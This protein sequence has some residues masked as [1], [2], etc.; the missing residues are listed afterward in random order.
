MIA[1][2]FEKRASGLGMASADRSSEAALRHNQIEKRRLTGT[3]LDPLAQHGFL[4][5]ER[6]GHRGVSPTLLIRIR[7]GPS[8]RSLPGLAR[9]ASR[10]D[11]QHAGDGRDPD[12]N[13]HGA[14]VPYTAGSVLLQPPDN[15][16]E[17]PIHSTEVEPHALFCLGNA[18]LGLGSLHECALRTSSWGLHG[19]Q[20]LSIR[21]LPT[22][23]LGDGI[24]FD[25]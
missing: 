15:Q 20:T 22:A 24:A 12:E 18:Y 11:F 25:Y 3:S 21:R 23:S 8:R 19:A 16:L 10:C 13:W 6:P 9:G 1:A 2:D 7:V 17:E 4:P 14:S 5:L